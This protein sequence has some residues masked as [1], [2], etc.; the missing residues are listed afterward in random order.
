MEALS[1]PLIHQ[2]INHLLYNS[3]YVLTLTSKE[4]RRN[5]YSFLA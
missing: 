3:T 5:V 1:I 2:Q 4:H